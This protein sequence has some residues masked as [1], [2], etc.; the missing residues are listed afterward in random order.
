MIFHIYEL[1]RPRM[2]AKEPTLSLLSDHD[3]Y[4]RSARYHWHTQAIY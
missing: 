3:R 4:F 2:G 1:P